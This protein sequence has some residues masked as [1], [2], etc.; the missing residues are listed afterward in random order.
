M[1][2]SSSAVVD[3]VDPIIQHFPNMFQLTPLGSL[4]R[5]T[6]LSSEPSTSTG[7][8]A[9]EAA[10]TA[11]S[12]TQDALDEGT[13]LKLLDDSVA[14]VNKELRSSLSPTATYPTPLIQ[15]AWTPAGTNQSKQAV[16][17]H[18]SFL[19]AQALD[20][21]NDSLL[22]QK[23][24]K[25]RRRLVA[26]SSELMPMHSKNVQQLIKRVPDIPGALYSFVEALKEIEE[27]HPTEGESVFQFLGRSVRANETNQVKSKLFA[28][29]G[30]VA[31]AIRALAMVSSNLCLL[32]LPA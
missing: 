8:L 10:P 26:T 15:A 4:A 24:V 29:L 13:I 7:K 3:V 32:L 5:W 28:N 16:S 14:S 6:E 18:F 22:G 27:S 9:I 1:A 19:K 31:I 23:P 21:I 30:R 2:N 17:W 11:S 20:R 12:S 25:P